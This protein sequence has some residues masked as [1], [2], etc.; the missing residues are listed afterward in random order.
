MGMIM[1]SSFCM[2]SEK[3]NGEI[4]HS[5]HKLLVS[6]I[7]L[8]GYSQKVPG[9][10][11]SWGQAIAKVIFLLIST[12]ILSLGVRPSRSGAEK[13]LDG[14]GLTQETGPRRVPNPRSRLS[15]DVGTDHFP[16]EIKLRPKASNLLWGFDGLGLNNINNKNIKHL[17]LLKSKTNRNKFREIYSDYL[18]K[19]LLTHIQIGKRENSKNY[20]I[21][22]HFKYKIIYF[23]QKNPQRYYF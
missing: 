15:L 18:F 20:K 9:S 4:T 16:L 5:W 11:P 6:G 1:V 7:G 22:Y 12:L 10:V 21:L 23:W 3:M 19:S 17:N 14:I 8:K 2:I 13:A